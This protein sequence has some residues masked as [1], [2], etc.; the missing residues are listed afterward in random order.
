M[1]SIKLNLYN[2]QF[3]RRREEDAE[4][5]IE[6]KGGIMLNI[7]VIVEPIDCG[8]F[9]LYNFVQF[10]IVKVYLYFLGQNSTDIPMYRCI[11]YI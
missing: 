9:V 3:G 2:A 4:D 7:S 10:A 6:K 8:G 11:W 1:A 5:G